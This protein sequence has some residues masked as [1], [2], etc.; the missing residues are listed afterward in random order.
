VTVPSRRRTR[1]AVVGGLVTLLAVSAATGC[2]GSARPPGTPAVVTIGFLGATSGLDTGMGA[3]AERGVQLAIEIVNQSYPDIPLDLGPGAGLPGFGGAPLRLAT[4]DT[5]GTGVGATDQ[6]NALVTQE[7]AV[8]FVVADTAEVVAAAGTETQRRSVPLLDAA[9]TEDYLTEL[10]L[11][12]YFRTAPTLRSLAETAFALLQRQLA[13]GAPPRIAIVTEPG[14]GGAAGTALLRD[15]AGRA[16]FAV[17]VRGELVATPPDRGP[18]T[19]RVTGA[20][21]DAVVGLA[22]T[23]GAAA[24]LAE[25]AE[26]LGGAVPVVGVG[27]GLGALRP[28]ETFGSLTVGRAGPVLLRSASWSGEYARRSPV[29]RAVTE[30]YQR[31]FGQPMTATAANAFTAAMTLAQAID[32]AGSEPAA[33]RAALRRTWVPATQMIMPW[34]GVRFDGNGQ[35]VLAAGVLEGLEESGFRVVYPSELATGPMVWPAR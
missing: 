18:L 30:L 8:A 19:R 6:V 32:Q 4:G 5:G 14:P 29:A 12:W 33:I 15:L 25:L 16:G 35:N 31:L 28:R 24:G 21:C 20:G 7:S 2:T 34:N 27:S 26:A 22:L 23:P 11:D 13:G 17:A 9:S 1:A 10:G 3:E